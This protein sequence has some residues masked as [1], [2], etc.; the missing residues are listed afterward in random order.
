MTRR[1]ALAAMAA[2]LVPIKAFGTTPKQA[3]IIVSLADN[4][5]QGIV[6]LVCNL[7]SER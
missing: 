3:R 6:K 1:S 7:A 5:T 4:Q 2:G